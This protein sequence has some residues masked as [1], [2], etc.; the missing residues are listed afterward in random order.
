MKKKE[1]LLVVLTVVLAGLYIFFFT[2]LFAPKFIKIQHSVRPFRD[3]WGPGGRATNS[4]NKLTYVI[5]F[6]LNR[7]WK[8]DEVKVVTASEFSTNKY[9]HPVWHMVTEKQSTPTKAFIYGG[10]IPGMHPA[11]SGTEP[12]RLDPGV[13]YKLIVRSG[14]IQGE[15]DIQINKV[16]AR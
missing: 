11:V 13:T 12:D 15:D 10:V 3:A 5:S 9:A 14:K 16:Q 7:E 2:D 4:N 1:I 6:V 8:L